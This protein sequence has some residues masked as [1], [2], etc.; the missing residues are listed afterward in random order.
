MDFIRVETRGHVTTITLNRPEVMNA[1]HPPMHAELQAAFDAFA[2]DDDQFVCVVTGA[3]DRA[4]CAGSDLKAA[5][6]GGIAGK[7]PK[8]GYAGLIERFD[9][10]KPV[11]AAVNGV[12]LGGGFEIALACDIVVAAKN[13][14]FALPE[15]KVG[16]AALG[17]GILRLPQEIGLKRAMGLMLTGRRLSAAEGLSL[18]FVNEVVES[19]ALTGAKR[20]AEEILACSPMSVRATK[21][22]ALQGLGEP[23]ATALEAQWDYPAVRRM[24]DSE[25]AAEGPAAFAAKRAPAWKGK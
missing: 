2:A 20:W 17:G 18:G 16:L 1:V 6:A 22:T 8:N 19:D 5:A 4:F 10:H 14:T 11:I 3:G 9:L 21:Q 24:L 13:A 15:V 23:L 25:D 7:Y 12:C